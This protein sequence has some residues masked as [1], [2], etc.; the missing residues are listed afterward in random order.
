MK[1]LFELITDPYE[2]KARVYPGL[3][4]TLPLIV[5]LLLVYG[6]KHPAL[7]GI[8][9]LLGGCGA[10]YALA[11]IARGRG[12]ILEEILVKRWGGMPT[13]IVLR[14]RDKFLDSV[15][16]QRYHT[17]ITTKLGI[18]MPTSGEEEA[19]WDRADDLYIGATRRLRELTRTNKQLLLK[20]NIAY[21]FHRNML[22]MKSI[23]I[24]SCFLGIF[25]GLLIAK[26]LQF[27]PPYLYP[28][29]LATPGLAASL[30]I[31]ISLVLLAAWLLYFDQNAVK[32]MGFVYAERL[33]EC[34]SSMPSKVPRKQEPKQVN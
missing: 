16:K 6:A 14:H 26:I 34:L 8:L 18:P 9:G 13:T 32:R 25:Y 10:I 4:V 15:S 22:A 29:Y 19:D 17:L 33:F 23:G 2:R 12:K 21:G 1:N 11:S 30:S 3:L 20:E 27:V 31:L 28:I 5:P 24:L 7:T